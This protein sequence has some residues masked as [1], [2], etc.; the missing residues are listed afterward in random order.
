MLAGPK[1]RIVSILSATSEEEKSAML[2]NLG[3]SLAQ[4]G[5]DVLLLDASRA[6]RGIASHLKLAHGATLMEVARQERA[7]NEVIQPTAQGFNVALLG[8]EPGRSPAPDAAQASRLSSVFNLLARQAGIIVVDAELGADDAFPVTEM[9]ASEIVVQVS[10]SAASI[11][12]A[13]GIIKRLNA[14]LG[15]RPFSV[16]VTGA[17]DKEA[18]V[19]YENMAQAASRY[20][21]VQLNSM[22]SV[23]ADE[24]LKRATRLGRSVVEAFPLA[25]ASVAFRRL[26]GR[27]ALADAPSTGMPAG[28]VFL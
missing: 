18:K 23:P 14:Q 11:K 28:G 4:A 10:S 22:G 7:L 8:R 20:L 12:S 25:G 16:L 15:R 3:A 1:P 17:T 19:V 6:T 5:S 13:Y 2:V 21:A 26:A 9:A 27:F 24:H